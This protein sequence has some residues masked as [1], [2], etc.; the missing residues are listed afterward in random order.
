MQPM[1]QFADERKARRL[2][3]EAE[4]MEPV[5]VNAPMTTQ[6][7]ENPKMPAATPTMSAASPSASQTLEPCRKKVRITGRPL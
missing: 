6:R 7:S 5:K 3:M 4:T 2:G 1:L